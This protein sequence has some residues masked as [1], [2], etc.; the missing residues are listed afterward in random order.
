MWPPDR[1]RKPWFLR[2]SIHPAMKTNSRSCKPAFNNA[3]LT[4]ARSVE[5]LLASG[6]TATS[7]QRPRVFWAYFAIFLPGGARDRRE[8]N[9]G[10]E[11]S[12]EID[13]EPVHFLAR[14]ETRMRDRD[15][16]IDER[17]DG[18]SA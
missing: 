2:G 18:H 10:P 3:A 16:V 8:T 1:C 7:L 14:Q 12:L 6:V 13:F 17:G 9:V 4:F 5:A 15:H 11:H